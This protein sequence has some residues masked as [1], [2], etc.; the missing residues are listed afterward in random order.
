MRRLL[1]AALAPL[2]LGA[3]DRDAWQLAVHETLVEHLDPLL[4][5][6]PPLPEHLVPAWVHLTITVD[7]EGAVTAVGQTPQHPPRGKRLE[8]CLERT[9]RSVAFP[10]PPRGGMS[11][12][13]TLFLEDGLPEDGRPGLQRVRLPLLVDGAPERA[14]VDL[15]LDA[16]AGAPD[17]EVLAESVFVLE[18]DQVVPD[19]RRRLWLQRVRDRVRRST[20][21]PSCPPGGARLRVEVAPDGTVGALEVRGS[22]ET[23][24]CLQE[25]FVLAEDPSPDGAGATVVVAVRT[26]RSGIHVEPAVWEGEPV[27]L[28]S[29]AD[30]AVVNAVRARAQ[31]GVSVCYSESLEE[32]PGRPP[33]VGTLDVGVVIGSVGE[34]QAALTGGELADTTLASCVARV[35]ERLEFPAPLDGGTVV[36]S[37]TYAF[38]PGD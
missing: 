11:V 7:S 27:P 35:H 12:V 25:R 26:D 30:Q 14:V 21:I 22:E 31:R 32:R 9:L 6:R 3:A 8:R 24:R 2:L 37:L 17:G 36:L 19:L 29:P 10:A 4:A 34:V 28:L 33:Q 15:D 18:A 16:I 5:C 20:A 1:L 13:R 23:R 38:R